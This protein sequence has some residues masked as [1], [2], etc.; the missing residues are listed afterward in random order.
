MPSY[1]EQRLRCAI[2]LVLS[3]LYLSVDLIDFV[4]VVPS[5]YPTK[6]V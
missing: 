5:I 3:T 2:V 1:P 4:G 6:T